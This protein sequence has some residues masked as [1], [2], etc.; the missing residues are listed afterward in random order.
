M[1]LGVVLNGPE[2]VVLAADTRVTLYAQKGDGSPQMVVNFDNATKLLTFDRDHRWVGAVTYGD[3]LIGTRTAHS[4]MPEFQLRLGRKRR[5]IC[6]YA[7]ELSDFFLERWRESGLPG[8]VN[9]G[10]GLSFIVGGFDEEEPYGKVFIFNVPASPRPDHQNPESFGMTWGGQLE[11]ASRVVL[12]YDPRLLLRLGERFNLSDPELKELEEDLGGRFKYTIPYEVLPLQDCVDLATFLIRTTISA[13]NLA[14][15][16]RGVGGTI[17]VA[18]IT[19]TDG[20]EWVQK[21]EL[22]GEDNHERHYRNH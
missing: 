20:L 4:L 21:K 12:G 6:E 18:T 15:D 14:V 19:R 10:G 9:P 3:A 11:I 13:Q 2:G 16:V 22:H 17:E 7:Q 1:S 5:R 8:E